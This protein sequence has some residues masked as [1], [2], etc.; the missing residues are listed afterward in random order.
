M[1]EQSQTKPTKYFIDF[2]NVHGAGLKG[3]DELDSSDEVIIIYSQ[4]AETFHIE[5]AIDILKSKARIEF[6]EVDGGTRNAADFQLIVALFGDMSDELD[7]AIVSGDGGFDAAIKMGERMGLPSVRRLANLRGDTEPEKVEKPK[8]R[9]T[10]RRSSQTVTAQADA[11]QEQASEPE[12]QPQSQSEPQSEPAA[13]AAEVSKADAASH[14]SQSAQ[15]AKAVDSGE[16]AGNQDTASEDAAPKRRSRRRR[17]GQGA[18]EEARPEAPQTEAVGDAPRSNGEQ[19]N[20]LPTEAAPPAAP[21]VM[22]DSA[23]A[24]APEAVISSEQ[25]VAFLDQK[26]VQLTEPQL[27]TVVSALNGAKGRQDFYHRIIKIERQQRGRALYRL[28]R[29][30]YAAMKALA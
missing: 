17:R 8:S 23:E 18:K 11:V 29:E 14:D 22:V 1:A 19:L 13:K 2:E 10:R 27:N 16:L 30:H 28:V 21:P 9:R 20:L 25:V 3:I 7:Y 24:D 12:P 6:V 4:A 26:G 5:Q 15:P